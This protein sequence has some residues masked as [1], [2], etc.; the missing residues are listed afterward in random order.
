VSATLH[1]VMCPVTT[2]LRGRDEQLDTEAFAV[3]LETIVPDLDG[4]LVGGTSGEHAWLTHDVEDEAIRTA[5]DVIDGRCPLLVGAA[6]PGLQAGLR[7]LHRLAGLPGDYV[8]I[9][10]P[11]YFAVDD[12]ALIDYDGEVAEAS[13]VP[14]VLYN[15][16]PATS[17]PTSQ[18][19]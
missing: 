6:Q 13:H 14:V 3:H 16:P 12:A 7:R 17:A 9:T 4:V 11:T 1:G 10:P 2:P 15:I 18:S 19:T 8:L 5:A